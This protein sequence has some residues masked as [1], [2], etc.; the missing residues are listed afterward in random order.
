MFGAGGSRA[1]EA[2][3]GAT[4]R[5]NQVSVYPSCSVP[6][7]ATMPLNRTMASWEG[8]HTSAPSAR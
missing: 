8:S 6:A 2:T 1:A 7:V 4:S 5:K 3:V